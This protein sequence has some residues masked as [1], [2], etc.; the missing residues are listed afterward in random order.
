MKSNSIIEMLSKI[1][2]HKIYPN[3]LC[4]K[5]NI[6]NNN[7]TPRQSNIHN[8]IY[9]NT[10]TKIT[11]NKLNNNEEKI[12]SNLT[13]Q[14]KSSIRTNKSKEKKINAEKRSNYLYKET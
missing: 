2:E 3:K 11:V 9:S 12:N 8:N 7:I 14:I 6:K 10:S 4:N 5:K 13:S 1:K